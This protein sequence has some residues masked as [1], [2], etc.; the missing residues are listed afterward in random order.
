VRPNLTANK[1]R[2]RLETVQCRHDGTFR[3]YGRL[4]R[5]VTTKT[6]VRSFAADRVRWAKVH[7]H[8]E[9]WYG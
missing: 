2:Y 5:V 9:K 8:E 3:A 7:G 1:A 6:P 4:E